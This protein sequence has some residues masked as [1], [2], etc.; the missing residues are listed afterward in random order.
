MY[1]NETTINHSNTKKQSHTT[2]EFPINGNTKH[3]SVCNLN[4]HV[5]GLTI[6][7]ADMLIQS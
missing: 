6:R 2:P 7:L 5:I 1:Y 3:F 4:G